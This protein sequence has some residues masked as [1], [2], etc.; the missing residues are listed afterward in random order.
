MGFP[1]MEME[2]GFKAWKEHEL[3]IEREPVN[4]VRK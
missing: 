1:V 2:G 4:R 3:D